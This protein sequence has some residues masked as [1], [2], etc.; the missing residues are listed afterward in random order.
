MVAYDI[1]KRTGRELRRRHLLSLAADGA[2]VGVKDAAGSP[3]ATAVLVEQAPSGFEVYSGD[4]SYTLPLLAVGAVGVISVAS[5]WAG[6]QISEMV[7]AF[8]KGDTVA[9]TALNARLQESW[10]F[11]TSDAAPNPVPTKAMMRA[12]GS[13]PANAA[14]PWAGTPTAWTTRPDGSGATCTSGRSPLPS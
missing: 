5:H 8:A 4:D 10:V 2:I 9:A 1:P 7:A 11:Q 13:P 3:S 6:P 12:S 14:C